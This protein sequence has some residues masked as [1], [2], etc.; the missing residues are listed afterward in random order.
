MILTLDP[1]PQVI[2]KTYAGMGHDP[3]ELQAK[4]GLP[5]VVLDSGDLGERPVR[6]WVRKMTGCCISPKGGC[7]LSILNF[8][9]VHY[10]RA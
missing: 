4:T 8:C 2:F 9:E 7:W 1:Q 3:E 6:L 10:W 5:V